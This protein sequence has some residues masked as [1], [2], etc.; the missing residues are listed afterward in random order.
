MKKRP[1]PTTVR[2]TDSQKLAIEQFCART[3]LPRNK[4]FRDAID[5]FLA[6][7]AAA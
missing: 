1:N 4:V 3:E 6:D 2:L 5:L 7:R